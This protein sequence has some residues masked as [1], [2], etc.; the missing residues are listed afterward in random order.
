MAKLLSFQDQLAEELKC[1]AEFFNELAKS[2]CLKKK[3][4]ERA[5]AAGNAAKVANRLKKCGNE[6]YSALCDALANS[7]Q[8]ALLSKIKDKVQRCES[9]EG[10]LL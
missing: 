8:S 2:G 3:E 9:E 5:K 6:G 7:G 10:E 4:L 1:S